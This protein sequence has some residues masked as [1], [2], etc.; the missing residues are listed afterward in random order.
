MKKISDGTWAMLVSLWTLIVSDT[1]GWSTQSHLKTRFLES[2]FDPIA[3][4][5]LAIQRN[6][7][8]LLELAL[9]EGASVKDLLSIGLYGILDIRL[10]ERK[11]IINLLLDQADR[12]GVL[13]SFCQNLLHSTRF[14]WISVDLLNMILSRCEDIDSTDNEGLTALMKSIGG[15]YSDD[16]CFFQLLKANASVNIKGPEGLTALHY[17]AMRNT[18]TAVRALLR[19]GASPLIA[20]NSGRLPVDCTRYLTIKRL[21]TQAMKKA[22]KT[23]R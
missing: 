5:C 2:A 15:R 3:V 17:A 4:M 1:F 22:E 12:E 19:A 21:L 13:E 14:Y 7:K 18:I 11:E 20:D 16:S 10:E 6:C 9:A 23:S 8:E